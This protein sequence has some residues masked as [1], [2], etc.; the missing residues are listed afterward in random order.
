MRL[1]FQR[2][3]IVG[4]GLIVGFGQAQALEREAVR[5]S[6]E[7]GVEFLKSQQND[8]GSYGPVVGITALAVRAMTGSPMDVGLKDPA[9]KK[10]VDWVMK[11]QQDNGGIYDPR[12]GKGNYNTSIAVM[13]FAS[14]NEPWY[15]DVIQKGVNYIESVQKKTMPSSDP[16]A[17][18][19]GYEA[20]GNRQPD[21]SNTTWALDALHE[22]K[23]QQGVEVDPEV[24]KRVQNF[25]NNCQNDPEVNNQDYAAVVADGGAIYRPGESKAGKII[26]RG[27]VGWRSYGSMT[28]SMLKSYIHADLDKDDPAVKSALQ[29][30]RDNYTVEENPGLKNAGLYYYYVVF[31][32]AMSAAGIDTITDTYGQEHDWAEELGAKLIALQ[33]DDGSWINSNPRWYENNPVLATS[34]AVLALNEVYRE[35]GNE[36]AQ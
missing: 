26:S 8:N 24:L 32:R 22:A 6:I 34:Y 11:Y 19:W 9:V 16:N 18:G 3:F 12:F 21:M 27:R 10:A 31:A 36:D 15:K 29:W 23:Q 7:Q 14:L 20:E 17:G 33:N 4:I 30:I 28:Y 1:H 25:L 13:M 5:K 2:A 35:M